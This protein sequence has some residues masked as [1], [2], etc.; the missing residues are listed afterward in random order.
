MKIKR[1][2]RQISSTGKVQCAE[3]F[4]FHGAKAHF[5]KNLSCEVVLFVSLLYILDQEL[6]SC[7]YGEL[8]Y[9]HRHWTSLQEAGY[10]YL[11]HISFTTN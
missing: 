10:H 2:P 8:S 4:I 7:Q 6:R 3:R 5:G 1:G 9:P 11:V